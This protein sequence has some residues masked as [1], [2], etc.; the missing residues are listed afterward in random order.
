[1]LCRPEPYTLQVGR[2]V[3]RT[4]ARLF[5]QA[6][7]PKLRPNKRLDFGEPSQFYGRTLGAPGAWTCRRKSLKSVSI[8]GLG[9]GV[10]SFRCPREVASLSPS[11]D[12]SA[13]ELALK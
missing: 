7:V 6:S 13:V 11:V 12:D 1:M 2:W 9:R 4:V 8:A 5:Q 3:E 10:R